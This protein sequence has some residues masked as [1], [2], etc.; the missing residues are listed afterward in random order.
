MCLKR[1]E[2]VDTTGAGDAFIGGFLSAFVLQQSN[3]VCLK[4]GTMAATHK[5]GFPGARTGL[6][7]R[8]D[9]EKYKR[10]IKN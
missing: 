2:V 4:L 9:L 3:T 10:R 8:K 7:V 1:G 5:L 6:P